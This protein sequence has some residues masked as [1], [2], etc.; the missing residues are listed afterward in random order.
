M[1][2]EKSFEMVAKTL[3]GLEELLAKELIELG[4]DNVQIGRRMVSFT[5]D[6]ELLYK[7]N[8]HCRTALRILKPIAEFKAKNADEVYEKVKEIDWTNYLSEKKTFAIDAVVNSI[9]FTHSKFV[10]YRVKDAI[11]DSFTEKGLKRPS[12]RLN[13]PDLQF[14]IHISHEECTL[15]LDSSG[16]SLHKRGYRIEE[17]QAPLNEVLAAGMILSTGWRGESPFVD[18][19]CGSGTL[20]IEAV[21]I[22]LN[23]PP[24]IFRDRYAFEKWDDFDAGLFEQVSTDDSREKEFN[25][26]AYGSDVSPNAIE[27]AAKNVRKAGLSKY[28]DLKVLPVQQ[29]TENPGEGILITNPPYGLRINPDDLMQIYYAIGERFKH[30]FIGYDVWIISSSIE[31]LNQIGLKPS[32]KI[33]LINGDLDCEY[34]HYR[35]F[36]GKQKEFK[37]EE[38]RKPELKKRIISETE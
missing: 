19:M 36:P 13:N 28:I 18:P 30:A 11:V 38:A 16:E 35:I 10:S 6:K 12:I 25:F 31:G 27:A 14:H 17:T 8:Y 5:G 2:K 32:E 29:L 9:T 23:L 21:L 15:A 4:A 37:E 3:Y 22:A 20:L 24:G 1:K 7:A 34:R 26:K 33:K